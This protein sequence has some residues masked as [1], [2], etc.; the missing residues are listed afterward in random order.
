MSYWILPESGIPVSRTTVQRVTYLEICTDASKQRFE[1]YDKTIKERFHEK[2]T[3]EALA[4]PNST[5]PTMEMWAELAEYD[6][7]FQSELNKVFENPDVK[8]ADDE[9]TPYLQNNY[10]NMELILD[11][12]RYRPE[13]ARA[14]KRLKDANRIPI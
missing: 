12:G 10:V 13:F 11:R 1:V 4:G 9:F 7:E 2:Y 8:E 14:K 3:G 6:K 5:N